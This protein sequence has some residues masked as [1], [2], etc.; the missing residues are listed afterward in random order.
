MDSVLYL[1]LNQVRKAANGAYYAI[2]SSVKRKVFEA[3]IVIVFDYDNLI[4]I[5]NRT[6]PTNN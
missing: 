2:E 1:K 6:D 4:V 3:S 5:K